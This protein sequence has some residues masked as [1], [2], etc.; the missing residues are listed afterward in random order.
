MIA[1]F[2]SS[3]P[4]T[5][6][7]PVMKSIRP[8]R[9]ACP[10]LGV[11]LLAE[12]AVDLDQLECGDSQPLGL[13]PLQD[14]THQPALDTIGL[15]DDQ[16]TLH[17]RE[18]MSDRG[19]GAGRKFL[20][21]VS[22]PKLLIQFHHPRNSLVRGGAGCNVPAARRSVR[23]SFQG[24]SW[25]RIRPRAARSRTS[26]GSREQGDDD[27]GHIAPVVLA[28]GRS[29]LGT[30]CPARVGVI[31]RQDLASLLTQPDLTAWISSCG[32]AV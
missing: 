12:G 10:V 16:G 14:L 27:P 13:K 11:V 20:I 28:R 24:N 6:G 9:T 21:P 26:G 19:P 18:P 31:D 32:S 29:L 17:A 5:T 22:S 30:A 2:P 25:I 1:S 4:T 15:E 3:T 7:P 23:L 8:R